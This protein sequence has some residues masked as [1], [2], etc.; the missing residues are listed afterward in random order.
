MTFYSTHTYIN[1]LTLNWCSQILNR[2]CFRSY[3]LL[4]Y[5][6]SL[7]PFFLFLY[8]TNYLMTEDTKNK[9]KPHTQMLWAP[10]QAI[11]HKQ[12]HLCHQ[13][14]SRTENERLNCNGSIYIQ[15][16]VSITSTIISIRLN[17]SSFTKWGEDCRKLQLPHIYI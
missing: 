5:Q 17:S 10:F 16:I 6:V 1:V 4:N 11:T 8:G 9:I 3:L 2:S 12:I 15:R 7:S 13:K 14:K